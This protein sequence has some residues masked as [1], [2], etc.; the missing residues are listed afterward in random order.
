MRISI[1][2]GPASGKSLLAQKISKKFDIPHIHI[3]RFWFEA[4][5]HKTSKGSFE[6]EIIHG[7][8]KSQVEAFV[9]QENWISDG[10]Y[11]W[12]QPI[13]AS[14]AD[15]IVFLDI[16][17]WRRLLNHAQRMLHREK[18]HKETYF[19]DDVLFFG[20]IIKRTYT[21]G[22]K[23]KKLIAE[24]KDK[25]IILKSRKEIAGYLQKLI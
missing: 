9:N 10:A 24:F 5:A 22:P 20:E 23:F 11:F 3:D 1:I 7:K 8:I 18:R 15:K 13:I 19:W 4:A 21:Y 12:M 25:V 16:P 6:R 2:G 17:L 14:R